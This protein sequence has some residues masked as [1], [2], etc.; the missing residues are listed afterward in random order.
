M[1]TGIRPFENLSVEDSV[2]GL[3]FY[4]L[5]KKSEHIPFFAAL[6]SG[7][8]EWNGLK[9]ILGI[10]ATAND[11]LQF[12]Y[13]WQTN[14]PENLHTGFAALQY[15]IWYKFRIECNFTDTTASYF[16]NDSLIHTLKTIDILSINRFIVMRDSVGAQGPGPDGP[17]E[18]YLDDYAVYKR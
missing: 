18:Y 2:A 7:G 15:D 5:A 16:M 14:Q 10:G 3:Q 1:K 4:F 9:V 13:E 8:S 17:K 6:G 12:I 11:S